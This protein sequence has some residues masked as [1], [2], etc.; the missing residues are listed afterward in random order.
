MDYKEQIAPIEGEGGSGGEGDPPVV[1]PPEPVE[2]SPEG[3]NKKQFYGSVKIDEPVQ[4]TMVFSDVVNEVVQHFTSQLNTDVDITVEIQ[5]R[6]QEGFDE[7][8]QRTVKENC[9]SLNFMNAEFEET[10]D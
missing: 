1:D 2:V 9:T 8:L 6:S 7:T 5:A 3:A 4:A 10:S